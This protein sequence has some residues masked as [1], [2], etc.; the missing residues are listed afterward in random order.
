M[1]RAFPEAVVEGYEALI[2]AMP[3]DQKDRHVA[4]VAVRAG[5]EVI[6]TANLRD[7]QDLPDGIEAQHPDEFLF[8]LFE[9]N[10]RGI[11]DLLHRQAGALRNPPTTF[12]DLLIGLE[13]SAPS[14]IREV[15][16]A[17]V[18]ER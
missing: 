5:A 10:L 1:S 8:S 11:I 13:K 16:K 7:F 6:V 2:A 15:R 4:A 3:N 14:F 9:L 18:A 17:C 12:E